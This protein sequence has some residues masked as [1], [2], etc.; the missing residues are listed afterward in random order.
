MGPLCYF[1]KLNFKD[2]LGYISKSLEVK[3]QVQLTIKCS[4][5]RGSFRFE[6]YLSSTALDPKY[7]I[8]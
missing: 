6:K 8:Y 3:G 2:L 4:Y 1:F 7:K 5:N